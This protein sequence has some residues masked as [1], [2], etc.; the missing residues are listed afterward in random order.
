M[1][2]MGRKTA[3]SETPY[4]HH[5]WREMIS[6]KLSSSKGLGGKFHHLRRK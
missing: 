4:V 6:E 1:R 2:T 3:L 5:S